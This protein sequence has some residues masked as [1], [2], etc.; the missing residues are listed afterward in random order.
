LYYVLDR[1]ETSDAGYDRLV[2]SLRRLE[3]AHPE[4]ITAD[5]PRRASAT[6]LRT[7]VGMGAKTI[8]AIHAFFADPANRQVL[9]ALAQAGIHSGA[10]LGADR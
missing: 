2:E 6:R 7:V 4:L 5:S 1:P 8:E 3:A 9:D 10:P